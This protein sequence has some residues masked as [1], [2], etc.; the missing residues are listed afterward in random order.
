MFSQ[1]INGTKDP[2]QIIQVFIPVLFL[3]NKG[4][5][6]VWQE[7]FWKEIFISLAENSQVQDASASAEK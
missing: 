1:L 3:A 6:T 4:K 5:L 7:E 2:L